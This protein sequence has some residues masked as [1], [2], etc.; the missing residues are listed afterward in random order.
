[1]AFFIYDPNC[2]NI[3]FF[4]LPKNIV[5]HQPWSLSLQEDQK[6]QETNK[7]IIRLKFDA[8]E[9]PIPEFRPSKQWYDKLILNFHHGRK[10][11]FLVMRGKYSLMNL[12]SLYLVLMM[13]R[14][15]LSSVCKCSYY[16]LHNWTINI[17]LK[18][19]GSTK[20]HWEI[21]S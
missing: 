20:L 18:D 13:R 6:L 9:T 7:L 8:K 3:L 1:M 14:L 2:F 19:T 12:N 17:N 5:V 11:K 10:D 4:L 16:D 21:S 15:W